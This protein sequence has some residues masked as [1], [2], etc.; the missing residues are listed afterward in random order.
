MLGIKGS[1]RFDPDIGLAQDFSSR[2]LPA[3]HSD[4]MLS[5]AAGT[6]K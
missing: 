4:L 5:I 1:Q 2:V 6:S 3:R